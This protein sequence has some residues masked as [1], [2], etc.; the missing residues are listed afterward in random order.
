V[1]TAVVAP[2]MVVIAMSGTSAMGVPFVLAGAVGSVWV[3]ALGLR[4]LA[5]KTLY[6]PA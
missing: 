5:G 2:I 4:L 6:T 1:A 3:S